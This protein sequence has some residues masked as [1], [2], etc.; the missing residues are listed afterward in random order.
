MITYTN[1]ILSLVIKFNAYLSLAT[2]SSISE[3]NG[4]M[5]AVVPPVYS[6]GNW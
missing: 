3:I 6:D 4:E 2:W 5:T 1:K